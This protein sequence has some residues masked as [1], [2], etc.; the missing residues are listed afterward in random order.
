MNLP[1]RLNE[2]RAAVVGGKNDDCSHKV[3]FIS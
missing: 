1:E 2:P 3:R